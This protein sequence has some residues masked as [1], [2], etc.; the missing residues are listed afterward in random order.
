MERAKYLQL[1][2]ELKIRVE[3][4]ERENGQLKEERARVEKQREEGDR[5]RQKA[6]KKLQRVSLRVKKLEKEK[7]AK[8]M[9]VHV[10]PSHVMS[11]EESGMMFMNLFVAYIIGSD[12]MLLFRKVIELRLLFDVKCFCSHIGIRS[13]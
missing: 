7:V 9:V 12:L 13:I 6:E 11:V 2:V 3:A 1:N 8:K 4:L 5:L 10:D